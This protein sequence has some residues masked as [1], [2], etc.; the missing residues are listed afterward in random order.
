[1]LEIEAVAR[2]IEHWL[3]EDEYFHVFSTTGYDFAG[4]FTEDLRPLV[5]LPSSEQNDGMPSRP[6]NGV[7]A[8][9]KRRPFAS[10]KTG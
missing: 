2:W 6:D 7:W 1:L 3:T 9:A 4:H 5:S 8:G 10:P